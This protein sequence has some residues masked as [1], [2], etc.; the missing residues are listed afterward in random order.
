MDIHPESSLPKIERRFGTVTGPDRPDLIER[1][2][3]EIQN[4]ILFG[5]K[6]GSKNKTT[7]K[8]SSISRKPSKL[9][10]EIISYT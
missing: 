8:L 2:V 9:N 6:R 10:R 1:L 4:R 7:T 3:A 5:D